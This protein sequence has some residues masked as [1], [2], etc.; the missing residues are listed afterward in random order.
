VKPGNAAAT[1][2]PLVDPSAAVLSSIRDPQRASFLREP[3]APEL[4]TAT[5]DEGTGG[6]GAR[7]RARER[8]RGT[9]DGYDWLASDKDAELEPDA[10]G[11]WPAARLFTW[12]HVTLGHRG[13]I[14]G[15]GGAWRDATQ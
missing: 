10:V 13:R 6:G 9:S 14:T 5:G 12:R 4:D 15:T 8:S 2:S 7:L 1:R 3:R 11:F